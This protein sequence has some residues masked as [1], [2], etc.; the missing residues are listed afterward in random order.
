MAVASD[1]SSGSALRELLSP[2][3]A[4]RP[5]RLLVLVLASACFVSYGVLAVCKLIRAL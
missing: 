1:C 4:G 5:D 2:A 3:I